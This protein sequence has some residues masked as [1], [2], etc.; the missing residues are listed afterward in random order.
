MPERRWDLT[1]FIEM[2]LAPAV[3]DRMPIDRAPVLGIDEGLNNEEHIGLL[4][5]RLMSRG[6]VSEIEP[7]WYQTRRTQDGTTISILGGAI[8]ISELSR[9]KGRR[10]RGSSWPD[11]GVVGL[12]VAQFLKADRVCV[13]TTNT[14][15]DENGL[16]EVLTKE[17]GPA[18]E[19]ITPRR[20]GLLI[21]AQT[22]TST[23]SAY[24]AAVEERLVAASVGPGFRWELLP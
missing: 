1:G 18:L 2:T 17:V 15:R 9:D 22:P 7:L 19:K 20:L 13:L 24:C 4:C 16:Y 3:A 11:E 23:L 14:K 8:S 5:R 10:V 21:L 6:L 12:S